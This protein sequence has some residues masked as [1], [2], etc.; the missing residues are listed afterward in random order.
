VTLA[1]IPKGLDR[2]AYR[3]VQERLTNVLRHARAHRVEVSLRCRGR[4]IAIEVADD[5]TAS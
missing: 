2:W 3:I 5:G 4:C 1:A